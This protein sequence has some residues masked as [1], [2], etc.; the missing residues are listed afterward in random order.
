MP[1]KIGELTYAY[2]K[3]RGNS[4]ATQPPPHWDYLS[5][6]A[7]EIALGMYRMGMVRA[8][9]LADHFGHPEVR[10]AINAELTEVAGNAP[11]PAG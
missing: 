8:S 2:A 9:E 11:E 4:R 6:D 3:W 5:D 7:K 1:I 10:D